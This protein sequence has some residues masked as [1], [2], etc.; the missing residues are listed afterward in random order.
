MNM[1]IKKVFSGIRKKPTLSLKQTA[2]AGTSLRSR[3]SA[4]LRKHSG[5]AMGA[6]GLLGLGA[7]TAMNGIMGIESFRHNLTASLYP[8]MNPSAEGRYG[9]NTSPGGDSAGIAGLKFSWRNK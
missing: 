3:M 4:G 2:L 6:A 9:F 1:K 8:G 5:K 7:G